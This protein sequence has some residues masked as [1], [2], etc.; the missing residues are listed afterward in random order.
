VYV[1]V[2]AAI[3]AGVIVAGVVRIG[4]P[5]DFVGR[6]TDAFR[7][8]SAATGGNLNRRFVT[9][10]SHGRS[11]YWSVAWREVK[12]HP[13]LGGGAGSFR[14]YWLRHRPAPLGAL[15]AHNLY[16]ETLAELGP[17]GLALL[18]V[19]LVAPAVAAVRARARPLVPVAGGAYVAYLAHA[20]IDWDWQLP[21]LTLAALACGAS[22][23]AAARPRG[24]EHPIP[25]P[26]RIGAVALAVPLVAFVFVMQLGNNAVADSDRAATRDDEPAAAADA[27]RARRWLRWSAEPW[28]RLGEAQLAE[29]EVEAAR[30]SFHGAIDRDGSDWSAWLDLALATSGSERSRALAEAS[31]LNPKSPEVEALRGH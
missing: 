3:A 4:N 31:R 7:S 24:S 13:L 14:Q 8:D 17:L 18:L 27:R 16:L 1:G 22:C 25:R 20:A 23:M 9:L 28:R 21:A 6:A 12:A 5:V 26:V 30:E 15:N 19:A 11:D 29:G 10:S 2:L